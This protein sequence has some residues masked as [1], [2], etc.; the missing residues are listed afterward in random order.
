[1]GLLEEATADDINKLCILRSTQ[2]REELEKVTD[3]MP[4][5]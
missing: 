4:V 3:T 5:Q 1:M 2:A